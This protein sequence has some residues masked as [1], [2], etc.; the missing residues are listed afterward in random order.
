MQIKNSGKN[1]NLLIPNNIKIRLTYVI[2]FQ[3][4]QVVINIKA[5]SIKYQITIKYISIKYQ[6]NKLVYT[7]CE[8]NM[9]VIQFISKNNNKTC[10]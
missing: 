9:I 8:N 7:T 10:T 4:D 2:K 5:I 6:T 3:D 1:I